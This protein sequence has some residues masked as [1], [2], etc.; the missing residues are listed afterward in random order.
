MKCLF[1]AL[2]IGK[3]GSQVVP[4]VTPL[5]D[6]LAA[7]F[8]VAFRINKKP[9]PKVVRNRLRGGD[10]GIRSTHAQSAGCSL[11]DGQGLA[12]QSVAVAKGNRIPKNKICI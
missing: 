4:W 8:A 7:F 1:K 2:M 5:C 3:M 10:K 12:T 6:I 11:A 9:N